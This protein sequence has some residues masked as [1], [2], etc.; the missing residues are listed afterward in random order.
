MP[1]QAFTI[2]EVVL[3]LAVI[4]VIGAITV[5][6]IDNVYSDVRLSAASDL[7]R[8][9]WA[10]ARSRAVDDG[11]AYRFA[12]TPDTGNFRIEPDATDDRDPVE[13][14]PAPMVINDQL[15]GKVVF[16]P[17]GG[18]GDAAASEST[19]GMETVAVFLPDGTAQADVEVVFMSGGTR[20]LVL[21]LRALTGAVTARF[22]FRR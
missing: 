3:V 21:R 16:A 9:R 12:V 15:P 11:I 2:L 22:E 6:N 17:G 18:G 7:V 4:I 20:G 14:T 5:P 8:A 10:E 1:R 19:D 13:G